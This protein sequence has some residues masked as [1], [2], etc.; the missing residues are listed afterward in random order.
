MTSPSDIQ[1]RKPL[2][3]RW[4]L[5]RCTYLWDEA[6]TYAGLSLRTHARQNNLTK[7]F[8]K[9]F[10]Y[11]KQRYKSPN[12]TKGQ[13]QWCLGKYLLRVNSER[14]GLDRWAAKADPLMRVADCSSLPLLVFTTSTS[15]SLPLKWHTGR[16]ERWTRWGDTKPCSGRGLGA[17]SG[18]WAGNKI[19]G[20]PIRLLKRLDSH[21]RLWEG[22]WGF[23]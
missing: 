17:Y 3:L 4:G 2:F 15:R 7:L 19:E 22:L 14:K 6:H 8:Q 23:C 18:H 21:T 12:W 5:G 11:G 9:S 20:L 10:R 13:S 1:G 16:R